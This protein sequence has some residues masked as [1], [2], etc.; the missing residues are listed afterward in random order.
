[1]IE[2]DLRLAY[3]AFSLEVQQALPAQGI[4][5]FFGPSG[6]GKT[7]LLRAI[8]GL[9]RAQ[10]RVSLG[11][12]SW[13]DDAHGVFIPPHRRSLGYVIQEAALF[14]HLDVQRNLDFGLK[15]TRPVE[16]RIPL[17]QVIELL[18][19]AHLM[20]RRTTTL[21]GGERQR[22]AIAR[23]L[24][25]SPRLLLMDEPMAALDAPR[26][27]EVLPYLERLHRELSLPILYVSHAIDE[28]ARLADHLL[29]MEAGRVRAAGSLTDVMSRLD[30]P[31]SLGDDAGVVL[32]GIVAERD[33]QWQLARLD[34]PDAECHFWARDHAHP[35]GQRVRLR[36]LA[37]DVSIT[38]AP[39]TG[40]S[41]GNQLPGQVEAIAGDELH[42]ALALVRVRVGR[43]AVIA[44]VT[45]RSVHA[46]QLAPG[47]PVWAQVKTVALME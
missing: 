4:T 40:T 7:T 42:P 47:M 22:V 16:R 19:I 33:P 21:S 5:A 24:A 18:G 10:G 25:T 30:L 15:R 27:R 26:K 36:V 37:R 23:A 12:E 34:V 9:A 41:I 39:Q 13:Q 32:D 46:L 6:C 1:M 3:P 20:Q 31:P 11:A 8:A 43:A 38:C 29:V 45:R 2:I 17:D 14:P 28:V 44:R 35:V